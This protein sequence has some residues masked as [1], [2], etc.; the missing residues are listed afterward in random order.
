[1]GGSSRTRW[2]HTHTHTSIHTGRWNTNSNHSHT[3]TH[4]RMDQRSH[5]DVVDS[6]GFVQLDDCEQNSRGVEPHY[7]TQAPTKMSARLYVHLTTHTWGWWFMPRVCFKTKKSLVN[8]LG[9]GWRWSLKVRRARAHV[10]C[11]D[12]FW[13]R[14]RWRRTWLCLLIV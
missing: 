11:L 2:P 1:M 12:S 13:P 3:Y 4:T 8:C 7:W 9:G 6:L 14:L 5:Q 10:L